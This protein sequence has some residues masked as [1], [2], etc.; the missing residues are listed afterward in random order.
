MNPL[1]SCVICAHDYE[2]YV[3][4]AVRSALEQEGMPPGSVE[5]I[6]VDDGSTDRTPQ[7]LAG[8]GDRI[9]VIR[10]A[11]QGAAVATNTGIAASRGAYVSL[12]DADDEWL[13]DRL[14]RVVDL[15]ERRPEV[16]LVHG[17]MVVVDGAGEVLH[18]SMLQWSG[19][20]ASSGRV[21]GEYLRDNQA[22]TSAITLRG[23]LARALPPAPAWMSCRDWWLAAQVAARHEIAVA[24]GPVARYRVHGANGFAFGHGDPQAELRLLER[25]VRVRRLL[26]RTL[27]LAS[28]PLPELAAAWSHHV[29]AMDLVAQR[30]G[31]PVDDLLAV[32]DADRAEADARLREALDRRDRDPAGAARAAVAALA[33]DPGRADAF[34][35]FHDLAAA[36]GAAPVPPPAIRRAVLGRLRG[37]LAARAHAL[38]LEQLLGR[39]QQLEQQR[40]LVDAALGPA[41]VGAG[42]RDRGL[43]AVAAALASADRGDDVAAA[44]S[45][46]AA[47]CHNPADAHAQFALQ[48]A[49]GRLGGRPAPPR[50][51]AARERLSGPRPPAVDDARAFVAIALADELAA[52]PG[53][54]RA[55]AEAF[56]GGD[57]ATL[58][59]YAPGRTPGD[60]QAQVLAALDAA[61][62]SADDDR[63]MTLIAAAHPDPGVEARLAGDAL[64]LLGRARAAG[65]LGG[66]PPLATPEALRERARRRWDHD[67][68]GRPLSVAIKICAPRWA[69]AE[70]WGD[71]HF[72][73]AVADEL[74][75]RGHR[76][77]VQVIEEWDDPDGRA[78]DVALHLRGLDAYVPRDDEVSV[79]WCISHPERVTPAECDRYDVAFSASPRHAAELSRRTR[80]PVL[81]LPQATD[82]T[83]FFPDPDPAHARDVVFV[84]N[85]RRTVRPIVRD[86][87]PT[88]LDVAIWGR[89]WEPY[90]DRR[91]LAGEHLPNDAV[92]RAYTSAGVVLNDH[93]DDMRA[94]GFVSNR[95]FDALACGATVVSDD[96]PELDELLP[97]AV[98][99][100][101]ARDDLHATLR[102]ELADPEGR[103]E[104]GARAREL[105]LAR[106]TFAA[107]VDT[108]LDAVAPRVRAG[109]A[110]G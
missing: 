42:D 70:S 71:L 87:L 22:T 76:A 53:L 104:R 95:V 55:W 4:R 39:W 88:D 10:Q 84:G 26:L 35:L 36:A 20:P 105:V 44:R 85:S 77:I 110:R 18:P 83:V 15:L 86:L 90:V 33:A 62:L 5:V 32:D 61:G 24:D 37:E 102:R 51:A 14:R 31:R 17:D 66:L 109:A 100:Y 34:S 60:A 1:V 93:W 108:L 9:R 28:V 46:V 92:R 96:V 21:L 65:A 54:L 58:A 38:P 103:R 73:R 72:A 78:C 57:D 11:N 29:M 74:R 69:G 94:Q 27:D 8:F 43:D 3:E 49:V 99:R 63:D 106:H 19:V 47:L 12:L 41:P 81:A 25:A 13:P 16:G 48:A 97:G 45:L 40:G 98:L 6:V 30:R 79:L 91:H 80:R 59:V 89:D 67:G 52:D 101:R 56:D 7:L 2:A 82:P 64:A 107:R 50:D 75:R 23:D 68:A